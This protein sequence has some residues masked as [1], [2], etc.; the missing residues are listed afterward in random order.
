[1]T[2]RTGLDI[3]TLHYLAVQQG[4]VNTHRPVYS[5]IMV[6]CMLTRQTDPGFFLEIKFK[7]RYCFCAERKYEKHSKNK[8][9]LLPFWGESKTFPPK[10]PEKNTLTD[11]V[12]SGEWLQSVTKCQGGLFLS[13]AQ[14]SAHIVRINC[15]NRVPL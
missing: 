7:G 3:I 9:N 8:Q 12:H 2:D 13:F 10:G 6:T 11:T 1:M 5:K 14:T 15:Q 4:M